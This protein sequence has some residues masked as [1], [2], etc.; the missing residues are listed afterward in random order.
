MH[1]L[2]PS[3]VGSA[4][5]RVVADHDEGDARTISSL[6]VVHGGQVEAG[7]CGFR[8]VLTSQVADVVGAADVDTDKDFGGGRC[9]V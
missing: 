1:I 9:S 4:P 3:E 5:R 7:V 6:E 2:F 8:G